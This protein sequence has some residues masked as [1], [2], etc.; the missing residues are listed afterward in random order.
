MADIISSLSSDAG[1][2]FIYIIDRYQELEKIHK[3]F[4]QNRGVKIDLILDSDLS[5]ADIELRCAIDGVNK[6]INE[7]NI[8]N[9]E[10]N[11]LEK[12]SREINDVVS[13]SEYVIGQINKKNEVV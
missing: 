5:Q 11:R 9:L 6:M 13:F 8:F 2:Y 3:E 7:T 12:I 4:F 10:V 1:K